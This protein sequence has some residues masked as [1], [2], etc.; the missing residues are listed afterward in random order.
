MYLD[1]VAT[2]KATIGCQPKFIVTNRMCDISG[3][4]NIFL[5]KNDH[6]FFLVFFISYSLM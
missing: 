5:Y 4:T 6:E 1:E 2:R 3:K